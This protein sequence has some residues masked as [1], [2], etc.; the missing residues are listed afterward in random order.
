[1]PQG[2]H[3]FLLVEIES[4]TP[5]SNHRIPAAFKVTESIVGSSG[6]ILVNYERAGA[7][8]TGTFAQ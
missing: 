5:Q 1:L 6:V 8:Q 7:V 4:V 3:I 2:L